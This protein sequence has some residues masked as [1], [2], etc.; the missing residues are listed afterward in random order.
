MLGSKFRK[1]VMEEI[2]NLKQQH[3]ELNER[4]E[5]HKKRVMEEIVNLKNQHFELNERYEKHK[6][7][8]T[9]ECHIDIEDHFIDKRFREKLEEVIKK[10]FSKLVPKML[11]SAITGKTTDIENIIDY[12]MDAIRGCYD[13]L[14]SDVKK[15]IL[16][17]VEAVHIRKTAELINSQAFINK[18]VEAINKK[19]LKKG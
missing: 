12:D 11:Y 17:H 19:Q 4:Y 18:V 5:K 10:R 1:H 16:D 13:L 14:I 6:K 2:M 7:R 9:A 3:F 15:D 8:G